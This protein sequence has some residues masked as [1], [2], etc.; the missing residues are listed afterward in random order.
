MKKQIFTLTAAAM[1]LS[2]VV[3][4]QQ[5][6]AEINTNVK[7][8]NDIDSVSYV[9]GL[10]LGS[11]FARDL[12][13]M[14]L[15]PF[16]AGFKKA[17][18]KDTANF[19]VTPQQANNIV[20][21]YMTK[22]SQQQL[23]ENLATAEKFLAEN[24]TKEGVVTT[25]SG[26]QYKVI[27]P[28]DGKQFPTDEDE[29]ECLYRGTFINGQE[30]D[31]TDLRGDQPTRFPINGVIKGWTEML[32]LMSLG[33]KVQVWI[34]PNLGYGQMDNGVIEPNSLLIFEMELVQIIKPEPAPQDKSKDKDN[35]KK[36]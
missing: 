4:C 33:E 35:K 25:E 26:L 3:S 11:Q 5:K 14:S 7:L 8:S 17:L 21:D 32:K 2:A 12:P 18:D 9:L 10:N 22:K 27:K 23:A 16:L 36:K 20:R 19:G 15:E 24:K 13:E 29:V 34:H 28:G 6:G 30:F 31:G 1:M